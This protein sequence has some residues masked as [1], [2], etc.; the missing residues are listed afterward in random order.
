M[1]ACVFRAR[2]RLPPEW[3]LEAAAVEE[4]LESLRRRWNQFGFEALI[5]ASTAPGGITLRYRLTCPG[6]PDAQAVHA[7]FRDDLDRGLRGLATPPPVSWN[8]EELARQP[9]PSPAEL[10]YEP[11][12]TGGDWGR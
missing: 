12:D 1:E 3:G 5:R 9:A 10:T 11:D 4:H 8:L 2:T 6:L 7:A